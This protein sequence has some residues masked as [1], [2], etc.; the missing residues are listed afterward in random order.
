MFFLEENGAF[1]TVNKTDS[2][3]LSAIFENGELQRVYYFEEAKND[4]FPVVQL[5]SDEQ[6]L[7]GFNWQPEKRPADRLRRR[8]CGICRCICRCKTGRSYPSD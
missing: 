4:G 3:M 2:K 1:A 5:P 8:I 7:K 6:K